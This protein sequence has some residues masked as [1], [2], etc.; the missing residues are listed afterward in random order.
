MAKPSQDFS[1]DI[2]ESNPLNK[3]QSQD[4]CPGFFLKSIICY[5]I[6]R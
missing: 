3:P 5:N 6:E 1:K 2:S 4:S